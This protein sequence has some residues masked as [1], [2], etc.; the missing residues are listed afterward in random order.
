MLG[1]CSQA[2][3]RLRTRYGGTRGDCNI[4]PPRLLADKTTRGYSINPERRPLVLLF[5]LRRGYAAPYGA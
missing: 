1:K 4:Y 5:H 2:A 3:K